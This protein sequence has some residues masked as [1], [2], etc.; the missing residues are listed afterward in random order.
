MLSSESSELLKS[1][2]NN[3]LNYNLNHHQNFTSN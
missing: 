2:K 1:K 3:N